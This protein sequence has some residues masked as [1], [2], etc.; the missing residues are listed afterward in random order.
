MKFL[1]YTDKVRTLKAARA[2]GTVMLDK[3]KLMFF[4][5]MSAELDK[6]LKRFDAVKKDLRDLNFPELCYGILHPATLCVT[7]KG[8]SHLFDNPSDAQRFLQDL[9]DNV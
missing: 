7:Y 4:S 2:V 6:N 5:D 8:K 3:I 9:K 1:N